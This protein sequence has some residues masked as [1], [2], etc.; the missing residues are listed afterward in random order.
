MRIFRM[1][2]GLSRAEFYRYVQM[3]HNTFLAVQELCYQP[4]TFA[5]HARLKEFQPLKSNFGI[6]PPLLSSEWLEGRERAKLLVE[7]AR[8]DLNEFTATNMLY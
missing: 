4:C 8:R 5:T 7:R 2:Q 3:H 1:I 6:R